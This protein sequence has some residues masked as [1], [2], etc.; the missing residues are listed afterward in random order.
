MPAWCTDW[1]N[2]FYDCVVKAALGISTMDGSKSLYCRIICCPLGSCLAMSLFPA[3]AWGDGNNHRSWA[4][5]GTA[6]SHDVSVID[7]SANKHLIRSN[8]V[9]SMPEL[10]I[11]NKSKVSE[12][13]VSSFVYKAFKDPKKLAEQAAASAAYVGLDMIGAAK[14]LKESVEYIKDKTR[15]NFGDCGKVQFSSKVKAETCLMDDSKIEL[16][17]DYKLDSFTVN[18]KWSL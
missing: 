13:K 12:K 4:S 11:R 9:N 15:F 18:F 5:Y 7:R 17:S 1:Q 3:I 10:S 16:N 6:Y 14:P 8:N 2:V